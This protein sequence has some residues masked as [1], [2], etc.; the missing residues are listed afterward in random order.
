VNRSKRIR[1]K[2]ECTIYSKI[3]QER[4]YFQKL[5][6]DGGTKLK[7]DLK[8]CWKVCSGHTRRDL[9]KHSNEQ[10]SST[11]GEELLDQAR[12]STSC[13]QRT[14]VRRNH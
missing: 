7:R 6:A 8:L 5:D 12:D 14:V 2:D 10:I 1:H 9:Y 4:D 13:S 11:Q 3:L